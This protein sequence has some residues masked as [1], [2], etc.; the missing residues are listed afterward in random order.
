[1]EIRPA[2][3]DDREAIEAIA[4]SS[5]ETS[6]ALSPLEIET[7]VEH[8]FAGESLDERL[9]GADADGLFL[10]AEDDEG[11]VVGFAEIDESDALRW[12]HVEPTARG[13][14]IGSN[15]VERVRDEMDE[16]GVPF[17]ARILEAASEGSEFLEQFGLT[18]TD[19]TK[20]EFGGQELPEHV[21]TTAGEEVDANEPSV[22]VP[23][24]VSVDDREYSLDRDDEIPGT[25]SPFFGV[26]D[27]GTDERWG[28]FCSECGST[29]VV[30]D[31][32]DRLECGECGNTHLAEQWDGAYL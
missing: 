3:A 12:L 16:R 31:G 32:L 19:T 29:D 21:Y 15:L 27:D 7:L 24:S 30:A 23:S 14:G 8:F 17:T 13:R 20:M 11:T 1:M 28:Y 4:Q 9:D 25:Q 6:Y 26:Y 18:Q 5:L 2:V 10:V 22:E